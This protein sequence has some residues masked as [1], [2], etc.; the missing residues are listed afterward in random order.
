MSMPGW[1]RK[2]VRCLRRTSVRTILP[3]QGTPLK[4][5]QCVKAPWSTRKNGEPE[6]PQPYFAPGVEALREAQ[7]LVHFEGGPSKEDLEL[8]AKDLQDVLD[9]IHESGTLSPDKWSGRFIDNGKK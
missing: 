8:A 6:Q 2:V 9:G 4:E 3:T 1:L 5:S 7:A